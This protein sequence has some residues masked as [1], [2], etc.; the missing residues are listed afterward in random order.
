[1]SAVESMLV[2]IFV[3]D[4]LSRAQPLSAGDS[5][6][7]EPLCWAIVCVGDSLTVGDSLRGE[8]LCWAIDFV[9]DSLTVGGSL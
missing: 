7:G 6:R 3:G 8:P 4:S 5:L 9:G 2:F 1:M